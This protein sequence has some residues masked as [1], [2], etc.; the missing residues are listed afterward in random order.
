MQLRTFGTLSLIA[1]MALACSRPAVAPTP[2]SAA[3][4]A[5]SAPNASPAPVASG[6]SA[7]AGEAKPPGPIQHV[8]LVSVDGL[9]PETYLRPD[10]FG[11]KIPNLR[12]LVARG[13]ASDGAEG[14]FPTLTYPSH[15]SMVTGVVPGRHGVVTNMTF[16]PL[17][18]DQESWHWYESEF[19]TDPIWRLSE[20]AG[21]RT[22]IVHWPVTLGAQVDWLLPEFWR[23]KNANDQKLLRLVSTPGLLDDVAKEHGDFW[24]RF[25]PPNVSDDSLTDVAL[26]I[27]EKGR[28]NLL[29]LHMVE[30]DGAQHRYGL[31]SPEALAA[32]EADDRQLG[33]LLEAIERLGLAKSTAI[34]VVSDHGFLNVSKMVRPCVLLREA[35]LAQVNE[36]GKVT[37][38]SAVVHSNSGQAYVYINDPADFR[39]REVARAIFAGKAGKPGTGIL[40]VYD[41]DE[42]RSRGGDPKAFLAL[43]AA[44]DYQFGPGC[45]G[46]YEAPPQ[47][48]AT[49]GYDPK[50]PEL[51]ASMLAA[52]P[53]IPHGKL[54]QARLIDV[55]PTIAEWLGLK[56]QAVDGKPL[57]Y[58]AA[59]LSK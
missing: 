51:F 1:T 25:I 3:L 49:H 42:I 58:E 29:L 14:V 6:A 50:N 16:D 10:E 28:P 59:A 55:A 18:I 8:L 47:Y 46:K 37:Q 22:G 45:G 30:V 44:P 2:K 5:G 27:L 4:A 34:L 17:G 20:R 40:R 23:A 32:I 21:Y 9:K 54:R 26:H 38:W 57:Q 15:S 24:S 35:G 13:A 39:S 33:R 19:Q 11:L 56:L 52:G 41:A 31:K 43:E 7:G 12:A 36:A 48:R 53:G